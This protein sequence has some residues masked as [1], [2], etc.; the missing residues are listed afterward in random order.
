MSRTRSTNSVP[1]A[2]NLAFVVVV[3]SF[4]TSCTVLS[5]VTTTWR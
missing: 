2:A 5:I 1:V 4:E 3:P